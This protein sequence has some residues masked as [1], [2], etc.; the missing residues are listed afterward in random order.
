MRSSGVK[1]V[2]GDAVV[3]L[4]LRMNVFC[5]VERQSYVRDLL[6]TEEDQVA[7]LHL[8]AFH[9]AL[10]KSVLLVTIAWKNRAAHAIAEL[11]KAAAIYA[12]AACATPQIWY[13]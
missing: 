3:V 5:S 10:K 9:T 4:A 6:A 8:M 1:A 13:P 11:H 2:D 7:S 12:L